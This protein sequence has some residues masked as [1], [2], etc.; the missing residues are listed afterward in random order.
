[1]R[2]CFATNN[3]H[4]LTEVRA[5]LPAGIELLSLRDI[6]CTEELPETRDTLEGNARQ[7]AEY[8]WEHYHTACFAD[9]TGLEVEALNGAPGVYSARYAGPQRSAADNMTRILTELQGQGNR[10]ARFRTVVALIL[11]DG[12]QHEFEGAVDGRITETAHGAEGF[13]YDPIFQPAGHDVTFAEMS[14]AQKNTL[15]HRARAVAGLV[16][17]LRQAAPGS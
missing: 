17:F 15:S 14:L 4:K 2:L 6:G 10:R 5:L 7:K 9:D 3:D 16:A 12:Q 8:V 13:G 1:M 11:P